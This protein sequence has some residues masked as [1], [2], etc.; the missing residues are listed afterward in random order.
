MDKDYLIQL[1]NEIQKELSSD[2]IDY[3]QVD[4]NLREIKR[5]LNE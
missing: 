4:A 3:P 5:E 1:V 2:I